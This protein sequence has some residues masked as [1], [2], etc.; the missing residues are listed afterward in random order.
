MMGPLLQQS[1][2]LSGY[3]ALVNESYEGTDSRDH[4]P[5]PSAASDRRL[6]MT[7]TLVTTTNSRDETSDLALEVESLP[8]RIDRLFWTEFPEHP[9]ER[10]IEKEQ[11]EP[12]LSNY[13]GMSKTFPY[14]Q[15]G[16]AR[17]L[18]M[19]CITCD[20][21][22][23]E[24]EEVTLA[25]LAFLVAD[26]TAVNH[27]LLTTGL[28][29]L[30]G[31]LKTKETFHSALL[32][33]DLRK[34]L[35]HEVKPSFSPLT[36]DY[37]FRLYEGLAS[38]SGVRRVATMVAFEAHAER[39]ITGLWARIAETYQVDREE[40]AYFRTHVGGDDPAE[41]YHVAMTSA[42]IIKTIPQDRLNQFRSDLLVAYKLNFDWCA[43]IASNE[44]EKQ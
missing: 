17:D 28:K 40:L 25:V 44:M 6:D 39:M 37:L 7:E 33:D 41:T 21:D 2:R 3:A 15:A 24:D 16:A 29:G 43:A 30:S 13:L 4:R 8:A 18:V 11:F 36:R 9:F 27:T 14:L 10:R 38:L 34:I 5:R 26:E 19:R 22:V 1:R 35:G 20:V 23:S 42:M 31:I 32:S 12:L